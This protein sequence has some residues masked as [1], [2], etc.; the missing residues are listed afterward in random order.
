MPKTTAAGG[1]TDATEGVPEGTRSADIYDPVEFEPAPSGQLD[2]EERDGLTL[3][4]EQGPETV[5]RDLDVA[6]VPAGTIRDV[7]DWVGL[8][9]DRAALARQAESVRP[10]TR[11]GL[12]AE[13]DSRFPERS[14]GRDDGGDDGGNSDR[15]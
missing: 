7:L 14:A 5:Q 12:L 11:T 3:V 13:L 6:D 10:I 1:G 2:V 8:D 15:S 4:G 9:A